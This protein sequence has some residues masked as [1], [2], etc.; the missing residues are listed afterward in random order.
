[1]TKGQIITYCIIAR[2]CFAKFA[3]TVG[4]LGIIGDP[5]FI[6]Q[7][8]NLIVARGLLKIIQC[9]DP[10]AEN[11]CLTNDE[12]FIMI[13]RLNEILG[14]CGDPLGLVENNSDCCNPVFGA[15]IVNA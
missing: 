6:N 13:N 4:T 9:Y 14:L 3:A 1:M 12:I 10:D 15:T 7:R 2:C 8:L 5:T 11:N